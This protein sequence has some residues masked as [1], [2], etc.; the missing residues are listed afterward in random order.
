[1]NLHYFGNDNPI[2]AQVVKNV[3]FQFSLLCDYG[4]LSVFNFLYKSLYDKIM[5]FY[6]LFFF[7]IFLKENLNHLQC[8][9]MEIKNKFKIYIKCNFEVF[10]FFID[11]NNLIL[12]I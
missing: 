1:M 3:P 11:Y 12:Y 2:Y 10:Y 5:S 4:P 9:F 8:Y 7:L 6:Y